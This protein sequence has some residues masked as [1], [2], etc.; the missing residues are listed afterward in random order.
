MDGPAAAMFALLGSTTLALVAAIA[1]LVAA[2][3]AVGRN[4]RGWALLGLACLSWGL[5]NANWTYSELVAGDGSLFPSVS[6]AGF[7]IFPVAAGA[8]LWLISGR[9]AG[10]RLSGLLDGLIV[11]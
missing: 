11:A 8:G 10:S 6:D 3:R 4:R 2:R 5:G 7:L 9:A 1:G